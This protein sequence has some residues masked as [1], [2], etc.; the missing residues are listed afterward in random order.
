[1]RRIETYRYGLRC[2]IAALALATVAFAQAPGPFAPG[3]APALPFAP[4]Q[5]TPGLDVVCALHADT[6]TGLTCNNQVTDGTTLTPFTTVASLPAGT[7]SSTT[8][9][10]DF[11]IGI[12]STGTTP[13]VVLTL[14]YG[15]T[16]IYTSNALTPA[17]GTVATIATLSCR[18]TAGVS[19]AANTLVAACVTQ[20]PTNTNNRNTL[21]SNSTLSVTADTTTA[22]NLSLSVTYSAATTGN[23]AWLYAIAP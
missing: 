14:K 21:L 2:I 7:L 4:V 1:M 8:I 19:G 18:I 20:L 17:A 9:H 12:L 10:A 15:T 5:A 16:T 23:A 22:K 6:I 11:V 3:G 13:T